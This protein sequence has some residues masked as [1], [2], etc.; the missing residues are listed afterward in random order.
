MAGRPKSAS[1]R[2]AVLHHHQAQRPGHLVV[3]ANRL[4]AQAPM[5]RWTPPAPRWGPPPSARP[6]LSLHRFTGK[7]TLLRS[8]PAGRQ[9]SAIRSSVAPDQPGRHRRLGSG[10]SRKTSGPNSVG[11]D[12]LYYHTPLGA[13]IHRHRWRPRWPGRHARPLAQRL[14]ADT[15]LKRCSPSTGEA[16]VA[17]NKNLW[18]R[19]GLWWQSQTASVSAPTTL[20]ANAT[21]QSPVSLVA[22]RTNA[23]P[24]APGTVQIGYGAEQWGL[25]A[26][27]FLPT[28]PA[29]MCWRHPFTRKQALVE[30]PASPHPI[31]VGL[32]GYWQP[33]QL[34]LDSSIQRWLGDQHHLLRQRFRVMVRLTTSHREMVGLQVEAMPSLRQCPRHGRGTTGVCTPLQGGETPQRHGNF[35]WEWWYKVNVTGTTFRC[36][37]QRRLLPQPPCGS[38]THLGWRAFRQLGGPRENHLSVLIRPVVN[39]GNGSWANGIDQPFV[40]PS[41]RTN[42]QNQIPKTVSAAETALKPM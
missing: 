34:R 36:D 12:K 31:A 21:S 20:A 18:C 39:Y 27:L 10:P 40:A 25:A 2:P 29:S 38:D 24:P 8:I 41:F 35:A 13:G 4:S 1:W 11:I 6:Q 19:A 17:Y 30:N 7:G 26:I 16:P 37:P 33:R 9:L 42:L 23:F 28:R 32:S 14:S 5:P 15:V 22:S 3:G